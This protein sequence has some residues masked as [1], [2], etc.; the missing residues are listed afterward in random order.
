MET[1][2]RGV[3]RRRITPEFKR[4]QSGRVLR[5]EVTVAELN[6]ELGIAAVGGST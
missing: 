6:G 4:E 5:G 3:D 1:H 2:R